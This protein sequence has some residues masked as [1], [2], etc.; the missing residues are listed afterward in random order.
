MTP[1]P[2]VHTA[3]ETTWQ[4]GTAWIKIIKL[5]C[6]IHEEFPTMKDSCITFVCGLI[7]VF[8][9]WIIFI[10]EMAVTIG[11]TKIPQPQRANLYYSHAYN[12][13][14]NVSN[15]ERNYMI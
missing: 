1:G 15:Q 4:G 3:Y 13:H 7:I 2:F 10:F 14:N 8:V 9:D 5:K 12:I 6:Q 11:H